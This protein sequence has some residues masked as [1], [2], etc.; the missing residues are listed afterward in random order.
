M[1]RCSYPPPTST[2]A[3]ISLVS[4][5]FSTGCVFMCDD[6][7]NMKVFLH[8]LTFFPFFIQ[9]VTTFHKSQMVESVQKSEWKTEV[10]VSTVLRVSLLKHTFSMSGSVILLDQCGLC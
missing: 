8:I 6:L 2:E 9:S 4:A 5:T 7:F 10:G 1:L 3:L